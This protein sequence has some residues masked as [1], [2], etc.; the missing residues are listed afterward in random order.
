MR[1][2]LILGALLISAAASA[3]IAVPPGQ[4]T[5]SDIP[6][7]GP[8]ASEPGYGTP[9]SPR[10]APEAQAD[11]TTGRAPKFDDRWP[12]GTPGRPSALM[13]GP[14]MTDR[15]SGKT[16]NPDDSKAGMDV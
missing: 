11:E 2:I 12:T 14:P 13:P 8:G 15:G 5:P 16:L 7:A 10:N 4:D 1:T 3:Q 6:N 9:H